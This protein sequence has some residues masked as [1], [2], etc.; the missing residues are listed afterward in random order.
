M[1]HREGLLIKRGD[2]FNV[3]LGPTKEGNP[4][5]RPVLVI[6]NDFGNCFCD[7]I[8]VVPLTLAFKAKKLFFSVLIKRG[9]ETGLCG[10][11]VALFSQIRTLS[12]GRFIPENRLGRLDDKTMER[13]DRIIELSLG[14]S[15][16]QKLHKRNQAWQ[17]KQRTS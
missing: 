4:L 8:I 12:K 17:E 11:Y 3:D 2:L 9:G 6:Q 7:T 10:D 15:T 5:L 1:K 14:L 16:I 13:A